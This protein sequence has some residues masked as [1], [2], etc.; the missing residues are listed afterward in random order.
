MPEGHIIHRLAGRLNDDFRGQPLSVSSPQ[1]RFTQEAAVLDGS[2]IALAETFGK[3]LFIDFDVEAPAH[4]VYIHLGLIGHLR[5]EP[6][7]AHWGQMRLRIETDDQSANL[8]GPQFCRLIT[9]EER[10]TILARVGEDPIRDDADPDSLWERVHRSRRTIGAMLMDQSMFAGVGN[11]YRAEV[12]FRQGISPFLAGTQLDRAEFDALWDDLVLLMRLGV[13][14]GEIN[15]VRDEHMPETMGRAAR[16]DEHGG[17]V[18]VYRREG[19]PCYVC[20]TPVSFE[21]MQGRNLFWCSH[22]QPN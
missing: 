20:G 19:E 13:R 22:C 8:R 17:E 18:Y 2:Q 14:D 15:T 9:E 12:L 21:V 5:F 10:K 4:I 6:A 1:G 3:H 16:D 7:D 11:I